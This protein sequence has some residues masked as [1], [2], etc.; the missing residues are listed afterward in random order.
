MASGGIKAETA[1]RNAMDCAE[2]I[3]V[4]QMGIVFAE[5]LFQEDFQVAYVQGD[6]EIYHKKLNEEI[7]KKL[8]GRPEMQAFLKGMLAEKP[9]E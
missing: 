9:E 3:M 5:I 7:E 2:K 1:N 8:A 4:M 6:G